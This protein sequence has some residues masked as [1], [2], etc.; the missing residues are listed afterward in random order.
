MP[1]ELVASLRA[2]RLKEV[3]IDHA[4]SV[5]WEDLCAAIAASPTPVEGL[6][7]SNLLLPG[8]PHESA[9]LKILLELPQLSSVSLDGMGLTASSAR[10][11]AESLPWTTTL[12]RLSLARNP[13]L[14]PRGAKAWA[15]Y[16][17]RL[18]WFI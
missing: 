16:L 15:E 7:L 3:S 13:K 14:G 1:D 6:H 4:P 12:R 11:Y 2:G 9:V 18:G 17:K 5:G 10:V 8:G